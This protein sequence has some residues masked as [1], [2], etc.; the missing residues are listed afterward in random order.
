MMAMLAHDGVKASGLDLVP[1][2]RLRVIDTNLQGWKAALQLYGTTFGTFSG[3][4]FGLDSPVDLK[5]KS[6]RW[7]FVG[8]KRHVDV[9]RCIGNA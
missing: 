8:I 6:G 7:K 3:V 2:F 1:G 9:P 5:S 4:E